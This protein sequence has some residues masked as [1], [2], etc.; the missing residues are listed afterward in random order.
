MLQ[1]VLVTM[2]V[3]TLRFTVTPTTAVVCCR[4]VLLCGSIVLMYST[5][6]LIVLDTASAVVTILGFTPH[7]SYYCHGFTL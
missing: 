1:V 3:T 5:V 4:W 2:V 7:Y 6:L